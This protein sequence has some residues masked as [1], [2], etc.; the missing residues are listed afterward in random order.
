MRKEAVTI[1]VLSGLK[2]ASIASESLKPS[3]NSR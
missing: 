1:R 3:G 2:E